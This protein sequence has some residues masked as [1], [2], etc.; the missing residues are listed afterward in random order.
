MDKLQLIQHFVAVVDHQGFAR[1]ARALSVSPPALT[2]AINELEQRLGV[3]LLTRTTRQV[4]VTEAG[5]RYAED[6]RRI[7][8]D[9]GQ[10]DEAVC[11][12]HGAPQGLLTVTAPG[13]FGAKFLAPVV[14][15]YLQR[16]PA[17]QVHCPFTDRVLN[18]IDEGVDVALRFATLPD[19]TMQAIPVGQMAVVL[20]AAPGY[21]SARGAPQHPSTL[22]QHDCVASAVSPGV[23][24]R[25]REG[26]KPLTVRLNPRLLCATNEAAVSAACAGFGFTQQMLYKVAGALARG[27]LTRV[28]PE[29]D[30]QP[31]PVNLLH[32]E[33]RYATN[34]VRAFLDLT[35]ERLRSLDVLR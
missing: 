3:R 35:T 27:Q 32:R 7:L 14:S 2:R 15:E 13:W 16:Y 4:R 10:A 12:L 34:K 8:N 21:L 30:P 19:S 1:A 29:F 31:L 28:L 9:L 22:N 24:W 26:G 20:C 5:L 17:M 6:C 25:F 23:E 33:G 18:L 11:G